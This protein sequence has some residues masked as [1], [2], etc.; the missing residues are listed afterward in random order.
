MSKQHPFAGRL[1]E[2]RTAA[3]MTQTELA[4]RAAMHRQAIAKLELGTNRPTWDSVQAL[5]R[6]L[7][8]SCEAFM[9]EE[10]PAEV[11]PAKKRK[12]K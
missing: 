2:L 3:K 4:E 7:G 6:A 5:A 10:K 9:V 11:K 12:R 8:V 1:R